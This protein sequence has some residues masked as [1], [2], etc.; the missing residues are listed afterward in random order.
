[1]NARIT[2]V[3]PARPFAKSV[4]GKT[5]LL[6][7]ILKRLPKKI[8]VYREPFV[9]GGAV[10]FA[11]AAESPRRFDD[12]EISD[13]N[14]ELINAYQQIQKNVGLVIAELR[15]MKHAEKEYYWIRA[16]DPN[17]LSSPLRAARF[18]YLNKTCFN[19]LYRVNK[20]GEFNVPFGRHKNP[21]FCDV[22]NLEACARALQDV[23]I[24]R[25]DYQ[26]AMR[27]AVRGDALYA[28]PPYAPLSAYENANF[29]AYTS[30]G[31]GLKEQKVLAR[32]FAKTKG[33][34]L[35]SNSDTP[36]TRELYRRWQ[37][38]RVRAPRSVNSVPTGRGKVNEILVTKRR[39][40]T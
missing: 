34:V 28:D 22:E 6:P 13:A 26:S 30:D 16:L 38:E 5:A 7:E 15:E 1:M 8:S 27:L 17:D 4:G 2:Q 14:Y 20:K 35:L 3:R 40:K 18:I 37:I 19:G 29:T 23:T 11:L 9:G 21:N 25:G 24:S 33:F 32:E 12:A 10:F 31:F 36:L 39:R